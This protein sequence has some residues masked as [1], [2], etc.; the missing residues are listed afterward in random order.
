[1]YYLLVLSVYSCRKYLCETGE[2]TNFRIQKTLLIR[3]SLIY[4]LFIGAEK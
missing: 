1:M 3:K 4:T 2:R